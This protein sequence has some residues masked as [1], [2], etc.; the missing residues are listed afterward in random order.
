[1]E[2]EADN[3][4]LS[5]FTNVEYLRGAFGEW[6]V[7]S[8]LTRRI[9]V[10]HGVG[11]VGKSTLLRMFRLQCRNVGIPVALASSDQQKSV[12]EILVRWAG[13]LKDDGI[14]LER[15]GNTYKRYRTTLS[16]VD[17]EASGLAEKLTTGSAK[18]LV[19]TAASTIPGL[20]P[21][22]AKLGGIGA[23]ALTDWL[24]S[25]GFKK[26]DVDLL[27]DPVGK[28]TSDFLADISHVA[29]KRRI[30][31]LIDAF[32]QMTVH[33]E[34]VRVIAQQLHENVLLV[35]S[36]RTLPAWDRTWST[37]LTVTH[38]EELRPMNEETMRDLIQR[39]YAL[40]RS[41]KP[42]PAQVEA[43]VD[44][45][46]GLPMVVTSAVQ[47][48][49][50]YGVQDFQ[51]VKA[52]I[53]GNL[54]DCL[55]DGVPKAL[56]P[57]IEAASVVRWFDQ[58]ILRAVMK[59]DDI[60]DV[61]GELRRFPFVRSQPEGL[62]IHDVVREMMADHLRIHDAELYSELHTRAAL[63]FENRLEKA[64][65]E[66]RERL[67]L[68]RLYHHVAANEEFGIEL[69]K[70]MADELIRY[71]LFDR[72]QIL[73]NDINTF[74]LRREKSALWR[75][76]YT[77]RYVDAQGKH[78]Q[79]I[80][81]YTEI[82]RNPASDEK[83]R[84]Y[85][86]GDLGYAMSAPEMLSLPEHVS[87]A[88]M[89]LERAVNVLPASDVNMARYYWR[90][91]SL[92]R[93][94]GH[95]SD[96]HRLI[97]ESDRV[98]NDLDVGSRIWFNGNVKV[99]F[100]T[101]GEWRKYLDIQEDLRKSAQD[102]SSRF[103]EVR[104]LT[105]WAFAMLW[106]G[107]YVETEQLCR[108][109]LETYVEIGHR[110]ALLLYRDIAFSL[111]MQDRVAEA[112]EYQKIWADYAD[113]VAMT[114]RAR[115]RANA[116]AYSFWGAADIRAGKLREARVKLVNSMRAKRQLKDDS[117]M[118]EVA[119]S[120]GA[121]YEALRKYPLATYYYFRCLGLR[122]FGRRY[123]ECSAIAGLIRIKLVLGDYAALPSLL[124]EAEL[125]A[126]QY[127]YNDQLASLRLSQGHM[128]WDENIRSWS[129]D[130]RSALEHYKQTL[131]YALRHNRY[132]LDEVLG[133]RAQG[134]PL[135][136]IIPFCLQRGE[137][138]R[139]MLKKLRDWWQTG[140][141]DV[142]VS[143]PDTVSPIPEGIPLLDAE[144]LAR[145]RELGDGSLQQEVVSMISSALHEVG[146]N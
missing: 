72:L 20:G 128:A 77:A 116:I 55:I 130:S 97:D 88:Q 40:V 129:D 121:L 58:P 136:S 120:L 22:V 135:Q 100:G 5:Y 69:F 145:A 21:L 62:A 111:A 87:R 91:I 131:I 29:A 142:G 12:L 61:Y 43:I 122:Q 66:D 51:A 106:M 84:S 118:A 119:A 3:Q 53:V 81:Q 52:E 80:A 64:T 45:G 70:E 90:L 16:K 143:R 137:E 133:G 6:I 24:F 85:S 59:Q 17:K 7:A 42:D 144:R 30:V 46:R 56:V 124:V 71:E 63:Y 27:L 25:N 82:S 35:I 28:M 44:F 15:F 96:V 105:H 57:A 103:T 75:E 141:N 108:W 92:H 38:I 31:L 132:L 54:I 114:D 41:G 9:L 78:L 49:V 4:L 94:L 74:S 93:R 138:G 11:G 26:S 50:K 115:K 89:H 13:E 32:E 73:L 127:E 109:G 39:Y 19:E 110:D 23:E 146:T 67:G 1:M 134:T 37:W 14:T 34:W 117:G 99:V 10:I 83:L 102:L 104:A 86:F 68:E 112:E 140:L 113:S 65:A 101:L 36:G 2:Y 107:R 47:L 76:Y 123:F 8:T 60:R 48:W 126:Q 18:T 79:A 125:L 139:G 33:D 98:V 95:W